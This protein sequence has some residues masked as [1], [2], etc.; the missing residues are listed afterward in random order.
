MNLKKGIRIII[1]DDCFEKL[2]INVYM[3]V[4][5]W[6]NLSESES[7]YGDR[8]HVAVIHQVAIVAIFWRVDKC[9]TNVYIPKTLVPTSLGVGKV[10]VRRGYELNQLPIS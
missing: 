7:K 8:K 2:P 5:N 9:R 6:I 4:E 10:A 3:Y 1:S